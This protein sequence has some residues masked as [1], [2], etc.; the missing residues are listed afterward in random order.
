M[1]NRFNKVFSSFDFLNLEFA[2]GCRIIDFFSSHISFNSFNRYNKDS[3]FSYSHQLDNLAISSLENSAHA[4]VITDASVK[5]NV[6]TFIAHVHICDKPI[7][8]T[9]HHAV[10]IN[11]IE[12]KLF[13]IRY[14]INQATSFL[15]I[16]KIIVITDSIYIVKKIFKPMSHFF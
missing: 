4:L 12:A 14:G 2:P 5:N 16:S 6:A 8:K 10:N 11:S 13:A 9:L 7:V 15:E 3:L 1:D